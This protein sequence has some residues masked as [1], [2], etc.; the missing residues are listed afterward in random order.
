MR[1]LEPVGMP[2]DPSCLR[3]RVLE[4]SV[5]QEQNSFAGMVNK[6]VGGKW[7]KCV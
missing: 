3:P 1:L 4:S 2:A 6:Q 5:A 7:A